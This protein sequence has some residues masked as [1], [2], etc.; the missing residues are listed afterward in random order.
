MSDTGCSSIVSVS[1][2]DVALTQ[3]DQEL[4]GAI[5][6]KR[7]EVDEATQSQRSQALLET[8]A[9]ADAV[10]ASVD[11]EADAD[12]VGDADDGEVVGDDTD[13]AETG[14]GDGDDDAP[15]RMEAS[16]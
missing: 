10:A 4:G 1:F 16:E 8:I 13:A 12:V 15:R 11:V 6:R 9:A 2:H 7:K 3:N 14:F 5:A